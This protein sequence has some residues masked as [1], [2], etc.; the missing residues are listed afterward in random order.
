MEN[1]NFSELFK[2]LGGMKSRM[3]EAKKKIERITVTGEAGAGM[4]NAKMDGS[5]KVVSIQIDER[6]LDAREKDMLEEL[7]CGAVNDAQAK[8]KEAVAHEI[9]TATGMDIPGLGGLFS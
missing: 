8:M 5:G 7:V 9:R 1:M 3:D 4:V 6:L 2:N